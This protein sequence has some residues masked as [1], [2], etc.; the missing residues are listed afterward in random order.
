V[1][2][3][4]NL[5]TLRFFAASLVI[6]QHIELYRSSLYTESLWHMPFFKVIGCLGVA[7]FFVLSSF[8]ITTLL[9]N[10]QKSTGTISLKNFYSRRVLKIWPLYYLIIFLGFFVLPNVEFFRMPEYQHRFGEA[11]GNTFLPNFMLY[12]FGFSS[13]GRT[14]YGDIAFLSHTWTLATEQLFYLLWPLVLICCSKRLLTAMLLII[15]F[16]YVASYF[17]VTKH[18]HAIPYSRYIFSFLSGVYIPCMAFGGIFAVVLN[19]KMKLLNILHHPITFYASLI[20]SVL[21]S[22]VI[23]NFTVH[24]Y[25]LYSVLFGIIIL[26]LASNPKFSNV[27]ENRVLNYLGTI[28]YGMYMY[29]PIIIFIAIKV[30]LSFGSASIIYLLSF[31]GTIFISHLSF[32]YFES[33]FLTR[34]VS[35]NY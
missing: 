6:V 32:K 23:K 13:M 10:E 4:P 29:H 31:I 17:L 34:R 9:L 11:N 33:Y 19:R 12:F 16:Y 15:L 8:L 14:L 2:K 5:D 20:A 35:R 28:S 7:M 21:L 25:D 30:A 3:I 26:N 18:A 22:I 1:K 27:L 24:H